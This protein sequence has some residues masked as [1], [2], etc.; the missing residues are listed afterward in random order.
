MA[1]KL[2]L[3]DFVHVIHQPEMSVHIAPGGGALREARNKINQLKVEKSAGNGR[4]GDWVF[5]SLLSL[6]G[7]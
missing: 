5:T 2:Y 3:A 7:R 6:A 4:Y 1:T